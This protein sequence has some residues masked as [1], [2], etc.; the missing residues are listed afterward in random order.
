[1]NPL[2]EKLKVAQNLLS[3]VYHYANEHGGL[4]VES[5]LSCADSCIQE[6]L[7]TLEVSKDEWRNLFK[8][9]GEYERMSMNYKIQGTGACIVKLAL[10]NFFNTIKQANLQNKIGRAH[11]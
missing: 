6:A 11:V 1:M 5:V 10:I 2:I 7:E 3:D 4:G 8:K 9:R